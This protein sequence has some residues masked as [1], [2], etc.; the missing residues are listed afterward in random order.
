MLLHRLVMHKLIQQWFTKRR[1]CADNRIRE[2]KPNERRKWCLICPQA[3]AESN[4]LTFSRRLGQKRTAPLSIKPRK[5]WRDWE[6][7]TTPPATVKILA[8]RTC[9]SPRRHSGPCLPKP[10]VVRPALPPQ[11]LQYE[12]SKSLKVKTVSRRVQPHV[13]TAGSISGSRAWPSVSQKKKWG[14]RK[15]AVVTKMEKVALRWKWSS[16][17]FYLNVRASM[18]SPESTVLWLGQRLWTRHH[19]GPSASESVHP[20]RRRTSSRASSPP[21]WVSSTEPADARRT[22]N[23]WTWACLGRP[24]RRMGVID[25]KTQSRSLVVHWGWRRIRT[26]LLPEVWPKH[27]WVLAPTPGR[28]LQKAK[29]RVGRSS[30]VAPDWT[31]PRWGSKTPDPTPQCV[32]LSTCTAGS[33]I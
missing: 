23:R 17:Q 19:P 27:T 7:T 8:V 3:T 9:S 5:I 14:W 6:K 2:T 18:H 12:C 33:V 22:W 13:C 1:V 32:C 11:V 30:P 29:I 24:G 28:N 25:A 31:W 16:K 20:R 4:D 21:T 15:H 26:T 10:P